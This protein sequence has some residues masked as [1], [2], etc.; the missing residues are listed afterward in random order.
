M[1]FNGPS[2]IPMLFFFLILSSFLVAKEF[3]DSRD[4]DD[5][6]YDLNGRELLGE[7]YEIN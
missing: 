3:E 6:V 7:R 4:A 5:C 1:S 2:L